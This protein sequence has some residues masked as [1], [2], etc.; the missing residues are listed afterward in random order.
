MLDD[1]TCRS[2]DQSEDDLD[3]ID[4]PSKSGHVATKVAS[5]R[6]Q[7]NSSTK[8]QN[9]QY[10]TQS[11]LL[12]LMR[13]GFLDKDCP[14]VASHRRATDQHAILG[15]ELPR[16]VKRQL[17]NDLDHHCTPLGKQGA[18][19]ALFKI[20]LVSHGYTFVAK[21]TVTAFIPDLQHEG[22]MYRLMR[23]IQGNAIPVHLGN[24]DLSRCYFLDFRVKIVHM[25]LMSWAGDAI[26]KATVD[27]GAVQQ[28]IDDVKREGVTHGDLRASNMVWSQERGRT[29]LVDF[30]RSTSAI[31][32]MALMPLP[33]NGKRPRIA[34]H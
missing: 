31:S 27:S 13:R 26:Y 19:G 34:V 4:T 8:S 22:R 21:G 11:C 10:C 29:M 15:S 30:E 28:A 12:G 25:M 33:S 14:N 3:Q 20:T 32:R 24:I 5:G 9:G 23:N 6:Q 7:G 17:S 18:R 16:L 2:P 1:R